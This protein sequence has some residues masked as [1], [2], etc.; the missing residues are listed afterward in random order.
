MDNLRGGA[1]RFQS[2]WLRTDPCIVSRDTILGQQAAHQTGVSDRQRQLRAAGPFPLALGAVLSVVAKVTPLAECR[3]VEQPA[4]PR[5]LVVHVGGGQ[6]QDC[7]GVFAEGLVVDP[8]PL[9]TVPSAIEPYEPRAQRLV[10]RVS[11]QHL[12]AYWH[13]LLLPINRAFW[14]TSPGGPPVRFAQYADSV[15]NRLMYLTGSGSR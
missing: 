10:L 13:P 9:A 7:P 3:Q 11:L 8:T 1:I 14:G 15:Q 6:N 12:F 5:P 4:S 2:Y